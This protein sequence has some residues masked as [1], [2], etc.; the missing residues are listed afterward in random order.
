MFVAPPRSSTDPVAR[1][2]RLQA[3][4]GGREPEIPSPLPLG[5]HSGLARHAAT[6]A[7][8]PGS[9][10]GPRGSLVTG[11]TSIR[12]W[13]F[14]LPF[15]FRREDERACSLLANRRRKLKREDKSSSDRGR[16]ESSPDRHHPAVDVRPGYDHGR[17]EPP[18]WTQPAVS[19]PD[20]DQVP[21]RDREPLAGPE[22]HR[23]PGDLRVHPDVFQR[24]RA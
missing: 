20:G 16:E 11:F 19:G 5:S 24:R 23:H 7:A 13:F 15:T 8:L 22:L 1:L 4:V 10:A 21:G 6:P 18:L 17:W 2:A 3:R 12:I 9:V 14:F